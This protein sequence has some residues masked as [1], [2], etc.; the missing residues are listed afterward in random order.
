MKSR[1]QKNTEPDWR[2]FVIPPYKPTKPWEVHNFHGELIA[3]FEMYE[4]AQIV[5]ELYNES[6]N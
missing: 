4:H 2:W 1:N 6:Q 5:V 3:Q